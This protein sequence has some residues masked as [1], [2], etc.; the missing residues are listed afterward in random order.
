MR[1][2]NLDQVEPIRVGN[3]LLYPVNSKIL[4]IIEDGDS[5]A[6]LMI[7]D[8][9]F[10]IWGPRLQQDLEHKDHPIKESLIE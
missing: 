5:A 9:H 8:N 10:V 6:Q 7:K 3:K 2:K 1:D 4:E